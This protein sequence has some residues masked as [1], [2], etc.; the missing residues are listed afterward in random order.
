[1]KWDWHGFVAMFFRSRDALKHNNDC[2]LREGEPR[3]P[4]WIRPEYW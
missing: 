1:M 2:V 4:D 3:F